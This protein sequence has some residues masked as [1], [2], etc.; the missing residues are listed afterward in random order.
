VDQSEEVFDPSRSV[1]VSSQKTEDLSG[2]TGASGVPGTASNLPRPTSRPGTQLA[3]VSRR[4]ESIAYQSTRTVRHL[5]LPQGAIKR[6]SLSVLVDQTV[7]WDGTGAQRK[8]V[9][10]PTTPET[11]KAIRDLV[12]GIAGFVPDRGDQLVVEALPF[13]S[14][15]HP[16]TEMVPAGPAMPARPAAPALPPWLEALRDPKILGAALGGALLVIVGIVFFMRRGRKGGARASAPAAL[17]AAEET[18]TVEERMQARMAEQAALEQK[19]EIEALNS[20][21]LP[22]ITTKK[23]EVLVKQV[24]EAAKKDA[25]IGTNILREWIGETA[26]KEY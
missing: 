12:S 6:M 26:M 11:L 5:R 4:T 25:T 7:R 2:G 8:R 13:E 17:E 19:L 16:E 3:G 20:I 1:M 24:K 15:L 18:L 9:L 10:V 23:T 21:K 14:T 22:K